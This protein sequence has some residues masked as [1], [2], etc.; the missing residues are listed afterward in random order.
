MAVVVKAVLGSHFG[1][2]VNSPPIL[3]PILVV[4]LNRMFTGGNRVLDPWPSVL[5]SEVTL[6]HNLGVSG[7]TY[8]VTLIEEWGQQVTSS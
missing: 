4:G 2:E 7:P 6:G 1:W 8:R 5:K 3:E